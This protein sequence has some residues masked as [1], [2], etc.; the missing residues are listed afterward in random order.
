[1]SETKALLGDAM[2]ASLV[3]TLVLCAVLCPEEAMRR[4][5]ELEKLAIVRLSVLDFF[6]SIGACDRTRRLLGR[7]ASLESLAVATGIQFGGTTLV[8]LV[9][10]QPPSWLLGHNAVRSLFVVW[11]LT[12]CC[13]SD[14]WHRKLPMF[15]SLAALGGAL[16]SGH[17]VTSWGADKAINADHGRAQHATFLTILCGALAASGGTLFSAVYFESKASHVFKK[18]FL[19]SVLYY[20]FA[21]PHN[22]LW[23]FLLSEED[24]A[25]QRRRPLAKLTIGLFSVL[26]WAHSEFPSIFSVDPVA[27]LESL[28]S[29]LLLIPPSS[30][31]DVLVNGGHSVANGNNEFVPEQHRD[32]RRYYRIAI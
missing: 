19:A 6:G 17:A 4:Y 2:A 12:F 8:G 29:T 7:S 32:R 22:L 11:W 9:L 3:G 10:G 13:P 31:P 23:C 25:F 14:L 27:C 28:F 5:E 30:P 21:D 18:A 1:M 15:R 16:S 20:F 24:D 26:A